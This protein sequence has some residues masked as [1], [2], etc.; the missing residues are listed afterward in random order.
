MPSVPSLFQIAA[1]FEDFFP[2]SG[3]RQSALARHLPFAELMVNPEKLV[4][5]LKSGR[6]ENRAAA[7]AA[8]IAEPER[9]EASSKRAPRT[10]A[11]KKQGGAPN[12][13]TNGPSSD[14]VKKIE[15]ML[16]SPAAKSVRL[17][18][19]FTGWEKSPVEMKPSSGGVWSTVVPLNPG[20]YAYRF[21]VDGQWCDDPQSAQHVPNPF[22]GSNAVIRVT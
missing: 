4:K 21:I 7:P 6:V 2:A 16:K 8:A 12:G 19:D 18:G 20:V 9:D 1:F 13:K 3:S 10:G 11:P 17:A 14:P 22:G 5:V 15:F